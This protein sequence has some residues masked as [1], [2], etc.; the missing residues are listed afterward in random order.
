VG[1]AWVVTES[2]RDEILTSIAIV[3]LLFTAMVNWNVYSW[4]L[5]LAIIV[6]LAAWYFRKWQLRCL[7]VRQKRSRNSLERIEELERAT[8]RSSKALESVLSE[9]QL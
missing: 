5:L 3:I 9:P 4:L 2:T 8:K 1:L 7:S 6:V